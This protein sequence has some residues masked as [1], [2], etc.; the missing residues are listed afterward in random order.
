MRFLSLPGWCPAVG[1]IIVFIAGDAPGAPSGLD[2]YSAAIRAQLND[3]TVNVSYFA[4]M[5]LRYR[6]EGSILNC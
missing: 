4:V 5:M 2:L 3:G 1:M 6:L